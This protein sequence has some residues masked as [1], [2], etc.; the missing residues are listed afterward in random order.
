MT[1]ITV[2]RGKFYRA[3]N[4]SLWQCVDDYMKLPAP[5]GATPQHP[6]ICKCLKADAGLRDYDGT[7]PGL[8][9]Y[10]ARNGRWSQMGETQLD[11]VEQVPG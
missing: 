2:R 6:M 7:Y 3:R 1:P 5:S 8:T 4:G 9:E 11:L 10:Y